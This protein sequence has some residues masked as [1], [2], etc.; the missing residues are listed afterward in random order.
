VALR[1]RAV[2][3]VGATSGVGRATAIGLAGHGCRLMLAARDREDLEV[4]AETCRGSGAAAVAIC[5]TDIG[6][7]GDVDALRAAAV[8]ALGT[9]DAWINVAAL[10]LAGDLVDTSPEHLAQLVTTNVLG[11][12][13]TS[14]AALAT[15]DDQGAGT[16]VNV[17]SLLGLLPNPLVPAYCT[18]KFAVRGLTL[19]LQR[20]PRPRSIAVCLVVPGPIDTPMFTHA[21]NDTGHPLRA[22]P[23]AISPWRAA[24]AVIGCVRRPRRTVTTGATGWALLLGHRITPRLVEW[25]VA[26][27]S[28]R[29]LLRPEE[30]EP[31]AGGLY[32][33]VDPGRVS[34]GFRRSSW[35]RRAG[36]RLGRW[37]MARS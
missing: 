13:L 16:L 30:V 20:S 34:G 31:T 1:G 5:P 3:I 17:S 26:Q 6:R 9:V 15:F 37:S 11:T 36:D 8:G 14:R 4:L 22:I 28:A 24:A 27:W 21:G 12:M 29:L 33:Q 25:G 18:T 2:V 7:A 10:L 35:R 19:T 32:G 23:P